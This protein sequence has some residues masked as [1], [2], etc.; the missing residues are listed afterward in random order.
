[1]SYVSSLKIKNA[2]LAVHYHP[3]KEFARAVNPELNERLQRWENSLNPWK[4]RLS[5]LKELRYFLREFSKFSFIGQIR[6]VKRDPK[7]REE[8]ISKYVEIR[9]LLPGELRER[10][11]FWV[12]YPLS[13]KPIFIKV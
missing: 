4:D 6:W 11:N 12:R 8:A 3:Y 10:V 9:H 13:L 2:R 1:M 5:E 7:V